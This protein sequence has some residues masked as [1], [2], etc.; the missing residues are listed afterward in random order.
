MPKATIL[1][2]LG[3]IKR[4][5]KS[6]MLSFCVD[7]PKHYGEAAKLAETVSV[8]YPKPKSVI[9]AGMGGSAI[10][11]ELLKDWARDKLAVPIEVCREYSLPAY[12]NK[13]TLVFVVSYSG[14]TEE[15]L[16]VFLDAVKRPCMIVCLSSGGTLQEFTEKLSIPH[17]HVPS[18]MAPRA[19]LPYLFIPLCVLMEKIG[20]IEDARAE[21][22]EAINILKRVS[23]SNSPNTPS[24]DNFSKKLAL[25][26]FGTVPVVY[27]F[28]IYRAVAQR[29]K[30]QFNENSKVPAK[31][32][33]F[34]E[35][36]HNEIVGWERAGELARCFS[37]L[38]IRDNDEPEAIRQRI[39]TTK[40]L[41]SKEAVK[42]FEICGQGRRRLAKMLSTVVIGDFA[43]VYLAVLRGVDP[44]PVKTI[45]LL[46]ERMKQVG[47]KEKV[48]RE[49]QKLS[50]N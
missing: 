15:S 26:V 4:I 29:L 38:F 2:N 16:S 11:G 14:E 46:K 49:L 40:E 34:P 36:N 25:N 20:L 31:W 42:I 8:S 9:V 28:G 6:N 22:S 12:T 43:S 44:T 30:Q 1:D 45:V 5:D 10:G 21:I 7:A 3:E 50:R 24:N 35:L 19:T 13:N 39:E 48:V 27:G 41:I 17:L 33:F 47:V 18:G 23:D 32:E 37:V